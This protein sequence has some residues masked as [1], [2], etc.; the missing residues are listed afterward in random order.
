M[1]KPANVRAYA[2]R[3]LGLLRADADLPTA[4]RAGQQSA[5]RAVPRL[6]QL[7]ED[8]S[9]KVRLCAAIALYELGEKLGGDALV[10]QLQGS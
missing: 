8:R 6:R 4:A 9:R 3:A 10:D 1:G 2:A 7:L 5:Q